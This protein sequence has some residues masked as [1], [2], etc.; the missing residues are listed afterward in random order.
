MTQTSRQARPAC[1]AAFRR[2][3]LL[4]AVAA[5]VA[6][7]GVLPT[8]GGTAYAAGVNLNNSA[9]ESRF[10]IPGAPLTR[11]VLPVDAVTQPTF[12]LKVDST[13]GF[14]ASGQ[15]L[16]SDGAWGDGDKNGAEI[17][18][19]SAIKG[20]IG[21]GSITNPIENPANIKLKAKGCNP[22]TF[23]VV[24]A[25]VTY[26]TVPPLP[27]QIVYWNNDPTDDPPQP[28]GCLEQ[29]GFY[30]VIIVSGGTLTMSKLA[31]PP[32]TNIVA[33]Q[34]AKDDRLYE[35]HCGF[36]ITQRGP[37][38]PTNPAMV[39][40]VHPAGSKVKLATVS[41]SAISAT[42]GAQS[43]M[44]DGDLSSAGTTM[45]AT[46]GGCT[47]V[48]G[49]PFALRP[50]GPLTPFLIQL[51]SAA[52]FPANGHVSISHQDV[53]TRNQLSV[54]PGQSSEMMLY[55]MV[56]A[57]A[58]QIRI[59]DRGLQPDNRCYPHLAT[60]FLQPGQ[61]VAP[62][63][64]GGTPGLTKVSVHFQ[65]NVK[66]AAGF[67]PVGSLLVCNATNA[68]TNCELI[69]H[70]NRAT[71]IKTP[72]EDGAGGLQDQFHMTSRC[73]DAGIFNKSPNDGM[74][75]CTF[76]PHPIGSI[77]TGADGFLHCRNGNHQP[78]VDTDLGAPGF[79]EPAAHM[80]GTSVGV[81][82]ICYVEGQPKEGGPDKG[83][84]LT[85]VGQDLIAI[86][87]I[88]GQPF[89]STGGFTHV[90]F[91]PVPHVDTNGTTDGVLNLISPCIPEFTPGVNLQI[92]VT[93]ASNKVL[94]DTET[95][96][97]RV[98]LDAIHDNVEGNADDCDDPAGTD[99]F[100][101]TTYDSASAEPAVDKADDTD[102]D[103]CV[104]EKELRS[105]LNQGGVRDPWNPY[106]WYDINHDGA[107]TA[108]VDVLQVAQAF[109][110]PANYAPRKDRGAVNYGPFSWNKSGPNNNIN[111]G[112]DL[113]GVAQQFSSPCLHDVNPMTA[114]HE[115]YDSGMAWPGGNGPWYGLGVV[116]N[117]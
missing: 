55:D 80:A 16:V 61:N 22:A 9:S 111:S 39:K 112:G 79:Q 75:N 53:Q 17:M 70:N 35:V 73:A 117:H 87:W 13:G 98:V 40:K 30:R 32:C 56:G 36:V 109:G 15:L 92:N 57:G 71:R 94:L 69:G 81:N 52:N 5:V 48:T 31:N 38:K 33:S 27:G 88:Q 101:S 54:G 60:G 47:G 3:G 25:N 21:P 66:S 108:G 72:V 10:I 20:A 2:V 100:T 113:L 104:D 37:Q 105:V 62:T 65:L 83:K 77:V 82:A 95:G 115:G 67:F 42:D 110:A 24:V 6:I 96:T 18:T 46:Q 91:G 106:D 102:R 29:Q 28:A 86:N 41:E 49:Q 23:K 44:T 85:I 19:Y 7:V 45:S 43:R 1:G 58:N 74:G 78:G 59:T 26:K 114:T 89:L 68:L 93:I 12:N 84:G 11:T 8:F 64:L 4:A 99:V 63:P 116:P 97:I 51:T 14:P 76:P 90:L 103:G 107:V 34:P 50:V